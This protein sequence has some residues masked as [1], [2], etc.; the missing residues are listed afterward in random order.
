M[1]KNSRI[2]LGGI[3]LDVYVHRINNEQSEK[4]K[5]LEELTVSQHD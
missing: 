5:I 4:L 3:G 1:R 2:I